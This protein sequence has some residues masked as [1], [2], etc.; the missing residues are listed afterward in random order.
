MDQ[1]RLLLQRRNCIV[2]DLPSLPPFDFQPTQR[3]VSDT[4]QCG[5]ACP[6]VSGAGLT[7]RH[8]FEFD[9]PLNGD[10]HATGFNAGWSHWGRSALRHVLQR[11]A[12]LVRIALSAAAALGKT[13]SPSSTHNSGSGTSCTSAAPLARNFGSPATLRTLRRRSPGSIRRPKNKPGAMLGS[14]GGSG[15]YQTS[16]PKQQQAPS[17]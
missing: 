13:G 17:N 3:S 5:C 12:T 6:H 8:D 7:A 16:C 15:R 14:S 9:N 2:S 10:T 11:C 1:S 4:R